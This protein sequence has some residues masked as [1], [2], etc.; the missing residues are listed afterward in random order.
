MTLISALVSQAT[1]EDSDDLEEAEAEGFEMSYFNTS[2]YVPR[3]SK[4][5]GKARPV[6]PV[7]KLT[8]APTE[9]RKRRSS[10][11]RPSKSRGAK[12]GGCWI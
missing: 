5:R 8:Y 10:A 12:K 3:P 4:R 6:V 7:D 2:N 9:P 1:S 11:G